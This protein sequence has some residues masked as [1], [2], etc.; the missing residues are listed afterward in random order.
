MLFVGNY[1]IDNYPV[2]IAS[3]GKVL[4]FAL[5]ISFAIFLILRKHVTAGL[6][7]LVA[8]SFLAVYRIHPIYQDLKPVTDSVVT[9][10]IQSYPAKDSWVVL[11][12]RLLIN[13]PLM[14]GKDSL[15]GV[16]FAPQLEL[17]EQLDPHHKYE[18]V[19]NR[20]AHV[21]FV[22]DKTMKE[23]LAL[24]YTDMFIVKFDPC[25]SFLQKNASYVLSPKQLDDTACVKQEKTINTPAKQLYIYKILP[26]AE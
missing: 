20:Y 10:A 2:F 3:F 21:L 23:P 7:V 1:T 5:W 8:F 17:W 24:K 12:D 18:E 13:F 4:V 22:N 15:S 26:V 6:V 25:G 16:Q 9:Q 14:A 19:Y 11:D